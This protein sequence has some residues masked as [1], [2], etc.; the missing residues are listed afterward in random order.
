M[1]PDVAIAV[2]LWRDT[3]PEALH[4]SGAFTYTLV[5]D[6]GAWKLATVQDTLIQPLPTLNGS[7]DREP[8]IRDGEWE[9]LFDGKTAG[10]WLTLAGANDL[11][12]SWRVADGCLVAIPDSPGADLRSFGEYRSFELKWEWKAAKQ[13]NSGVKYRLFGSDLISFGLPRFATGWEYQMA[14]DA[15]DPGARVDDKQKSGALYGLVAVS[16]PAAKPAGEWNDSRLIVL[17]DHAEHWLNGLLTARYPVDVP[18]ESPIVLQHHSSE[19]SFRN[20]RVRR[21]TTQ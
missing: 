19:V 20:I 12:G 16:R 6:N 15:A 8:A 7:R 4:S 11:G 21:I 1:R 10:H 17:E 18:F 9:I 3:A 14:D 2:G 13:S 5:Q